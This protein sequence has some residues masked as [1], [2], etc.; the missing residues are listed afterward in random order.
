MDH[1]LSR[2]ALI[3]WK[4][5]LELDLTLQLFIADITAF[6]QFKCNSGYESIPFCVPIPFPILSLLS[7]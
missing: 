3:Q 1:L 5:V 6:L 2:T 4:G 7:V